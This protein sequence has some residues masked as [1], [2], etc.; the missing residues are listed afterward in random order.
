MDGLSSAASTPFSSFPFEL[1]ADSVIMPSM[2]TLHITCNIDQDKTSFDE[3]VAKASELLSKALDKPTSYIQIIYTVSLIEFGQ[4]S[5]PSAK[6]DLYSISLTREQAHAIVEPLTRLISRLVGAPP[7]R[8]YINFFP[9]E[10]NMCAWNGR[11]L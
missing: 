1:F 7:P 8:T 5:G 6:V 9:L 10:R 2:P 11:M 3:L 4:Q